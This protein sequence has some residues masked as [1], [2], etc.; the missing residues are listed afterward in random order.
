MKQTNILYFASNE[1]YELTYKKDIATLPVDAHTH[2]VA[3]IYLTLTDLPDA[4]LDDTVSSVKRGS[5]IVIP[6][7]CVHQLYHEKCTCYE[8][9]IMN[10]DSEWLENVFRGS[11]VRADYL[12]NTA[13]PLII[14]IDDAALPV[15]IRKMKKF[16]LIQDE[17]SI[18]SIRQFF[19]LFDTID[20][21]VKDNQK[22]EFPA[23][24]VITNAQKRVNEIIAYIN[25]NITEEIT[26][27]QIAEHFYL[28]RDYISRLFANHTHTTI[29]KYIALQRISKSQEML[30]A[31]NTVTEVQE[32][33][34]YSSYAH[35]FKTFQKLT[36]MSPS[37]YRRKYLQG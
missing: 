3:E 35:Y 5:L 10:I 4:L 24:P 21:F 33:M 27:G 16:I 12:K 23:R 20:S 19:E 26:A 37:R 13:K 31:G 2:N 18:A 32:M 28:N 30:R 17:K 29:G 11:N 25:D 1:P 36:G 8:R 22:N 7:F 34:G 9:Y 14:Y 15:L 6:P